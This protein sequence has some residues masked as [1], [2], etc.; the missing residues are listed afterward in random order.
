MQYFGTGEPTQK[1]N[2]PEQNT[3]LFIVVYENERRK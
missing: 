2:K 1:I 3:W